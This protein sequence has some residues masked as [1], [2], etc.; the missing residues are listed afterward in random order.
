MYSLPLSS[1]D[2]AAYYKALSSSYSLR[3]EV[4]L[5]D[6]D[7]NVLDDL[8]DTL[9]DGQVNADSK[10]EVTRQAN[11]TLFDPN[12]QLH[13][14]SNAPTD[15][16]LF[17]DRMIRIN[18]QVA[19]P[20]NDLGWVTVPI[21]TGPI[22]N[23]TRSGT[24]IDLDLIGKEKIAQKPAWRTKNYPIGSLRRTVIMDLLTNTGETKFA[25]DPWTK[26][27]ADPY[28]VTRETD[29]WTLAK[30]MA[31]GMLFFYDGAGTL[32]LRP[33]MTRSIYTFKTG[34]GGNVVTY[35]D[36]AYDIDDV[37]NIVLVKGAVPKGGS[38]PV[39]ATAYADRNHPLSAQS[40]GRNGYG[41]HIPEIIEDGDLLTKAD[42]QEL[43]DQ[44][45]K[46]LLL[47]TLT[48]S[49]DTMPVP[50]LELG[51]VVQLSTP[52]FS[53]QF[54]VDSFSIPLKAG[55]AMSVGYI[56]R[57]SVNKGKIRGTRGGN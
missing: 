1:V 26:K 24:T 16:N 18:Y 8:S 20:S 43:A 44:R 21:F 53:F 23:M 5:M 57:R 54:A 45:L 56:Q 42:C 11:L 19:S 9:L 6:T 30:R 55:G 49:F 47:G 48:A 12:R 40:L 13:F 7:Q 37:R 22:A 17:L 35:P 38:R 3:I 31:A 36:I 33:W 50:T 41:R 52:E 14:D 51:D 25:L 10:G 2:L 15:G 39:E 4:L 46:E 34:K 32:V 29:V 27:T 28:G